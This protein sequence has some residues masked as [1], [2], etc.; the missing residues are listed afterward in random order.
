MQAIYNLELPILKATPMARC[1]GRKKPVFW[2]K[3]F[4][5]T[6]ITPNFLKFGVEVLYEVL[7]WV[8]EALANIWSRS[9]SLCLFLFLIA[10]LNFAF[11]F[12]IRA[13]HTLFRAM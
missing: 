11:K 12:L 3:I 7:G 2:P 1:R 5:V 13:L 9:S 10:F 4:H 8:K 6:K